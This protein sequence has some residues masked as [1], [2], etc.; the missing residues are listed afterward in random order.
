MPVD[1]RKII[2]ELVVP[3]LQEIKSDIQEINSDIKVINARLNS[4]EREINNAREDI[5]N[6]REEFKLALAIHERLAALEAKIGR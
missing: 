4:L 3:E 2:Q 5:R 1:V 6:L